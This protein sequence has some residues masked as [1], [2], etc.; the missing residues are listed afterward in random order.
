[1]TTEGLSRATTLRRRHVDV[2]AVRG[3][4]LVAAV[5]VAVLEVLIAVPHEPG[6]RSA[7]AWRAPRRGRRRQTTPTTCFGRSPSPPAAVPGGI[8]TTAGGTAS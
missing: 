4:V 8:G 3:V 2:L 5:V 6:Q 1:M 7:T